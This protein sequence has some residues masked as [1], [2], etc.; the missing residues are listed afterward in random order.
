MV[1]GTLMAVRYQSCSQLAA[2]QVQLFST[3]QLVWVCDFG[4]RDSTPADSSV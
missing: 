3:A 4:G 1:L 2:S